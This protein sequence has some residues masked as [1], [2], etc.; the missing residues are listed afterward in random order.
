MKSKISFNICGSFENDPPD[1]LP[2]PT[3]EEDKK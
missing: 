1:P 2:L 3:T